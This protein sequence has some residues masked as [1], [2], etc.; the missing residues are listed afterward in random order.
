[1]LVESNC[2]LARLDTLGIQLEPL[3]IESICSAKDRSELDIELRIIQIDYDID[4]EKLRGA[5]SG[6]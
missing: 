5:F 4:S 1:M 2:V 3:E 6:K